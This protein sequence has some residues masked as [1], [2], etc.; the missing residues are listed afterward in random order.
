VCRTDGNS[1]S[2][3]PAPPPPPYT[4]PPPPNSRAGQNN[5]GSGSGG[6]SGIGGGGVAGIVI[7]LLVVG[8]V[9]AFFLI[10]RRKHKSATGEHFEQHQ[11]FNSFPSNEVKGHSFDDYY[12]LHNV[13]SI[14]TNHANIILYRCSLHESY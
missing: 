9:V 2:T 8:A 13:S 6:K 12:S 5:D 7:S 3:G 10:K 11:P 14:L 4:A 1:W